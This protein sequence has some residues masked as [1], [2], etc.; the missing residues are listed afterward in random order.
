MNAEK[1]RAHTTSLLHEYNMKTQTK[2]KKIDHNAFQFFNQIEK[3]IQ[4]IQPFLEI[5]LA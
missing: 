3:F 5:S 1:T 4:T 2:N